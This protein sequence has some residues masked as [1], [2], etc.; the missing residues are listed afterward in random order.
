MGLLYH[1]PGPLPMSPGRATS[2][3][4]AHGM[5]TAACG[6]DAQSCRKGVP[7]EDSGPGLVVTLVLLGCDTTQTQEVNIY[8]FQPEELQRIDLAYYRDMDPNP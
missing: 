3:L 1:E 8:A 6:R 4:A 7:N 5:G 2:P